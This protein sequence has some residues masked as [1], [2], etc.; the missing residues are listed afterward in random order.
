M[1]LPEQ[2]CPDSE[3]YHL[4]AHASRL[5]NSCQ[6]TRCIKEIDKEHNK[7]NRQKAGVKRAEKSS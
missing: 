3:L 6:C 4:F 2:L 1:Y 7:H 5:S